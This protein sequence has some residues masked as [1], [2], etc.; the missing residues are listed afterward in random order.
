MRAGGKPAGQANLHNRLAGLLQQLAGAA[1]AQFQIIFGRHGVQ[2]LLEQPFQLAA[3]DANI[4]G[5]VVGGQRFFNI[6]FHQA[7]CLGELGLAAAN[8]GLQR[9]ALALVAG[10]NPFDAEHFRQLGGKVAAQLLANQR[11]HKV[12]RGRAAG[13]G[14]PVAVNFIQIGRNDHIGKIIAEAVDFLPVQ[15]GA[16]AGQ[17]PGAGHPVAAGVQPGNKQ[18]VRRQQR[19]VALQ[20]VYIH[21]Q[22]NVF[23]HDEQG[24]QPGR[25]AEGEVG[26]DVHATARAHPFAFQTQGECFK[27]LAFG[28]HI[29]AG[30]RVH[31][32]GPGRERELRQQQKAVAQGFAGGRSGFRHGAVAGRQ[33]RLNGHVRTHTRAN[34]KR[35]QAAKRRMQRRTVR[36]EATFMPVI[37]QAGKASAG[38]IGPRPGFDG[39]GVRP[40]LRQWRGA[41]TAPGVVVLACTVCASTPSQARNAGFCDPRSTGCQ[42][43]R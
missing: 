20:Q 5:N 9:N 1:Q 41:P 13:A 15:G 10:A 24:I 31:R 23:R 21:G 8:A 2:V 39:G 28:Q 16:V 26:G 25:V 42:H 29:G 4:K 14:A 12:Q 40:S 27:H 37:P 18:L 32:Q 30:Q 6:G 38:R 11:Q 43:T 22:V 36:S 3:G 7:H 35:W 33:W 19:Q 17:Q 34:R